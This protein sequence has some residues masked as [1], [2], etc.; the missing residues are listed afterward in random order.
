[1]Q[2]YADNRKNLKAFYASL[3]ETQIKFL[4]FSA[5]DMSQPYIKYIFR[6][7][8]LNKEYAYIRQGNTDNY[9][10]VYKTSSLRYIVTAP[11]TLSYKATP[12]AIQKIDKH[13]DV[14]HGEHI[15]FGIV[16]DSNADSTVIISHRTKYDLI[17][18]NFSFKRDTD[19]TCNFYLPAKNDAFYST[20]LNAT[21]YAKDTPNNAYVPVVKRGKTITMGQMFTGTSD[22]DIIHRLSRALLEPPKTG[23]M[24]PEYTRINGVKHKITKGPRGGKYIVVKGKKHYLQKG[25]SIAYKN[26]TFLSDTFVEFI[27]TYIL[28]PLKNIH[29][30]DLVS[31]QL[32]FDEENELDADSNSTITFQYDFL[33]RPSSLFYVETPML[34]AACYAFTSVSEGVL[35]QNLDPYEVEQFEEFQKIMTPNLAQVQ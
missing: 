5:T 24:R 9:Y 29:Q 32:F 30:D 31:V 26:V 12:V 23:G 17:S 14:Y 35:L 6:K 33:T 27:R 18:P 19:K 2:N 20:L 1:M 3:P 25:G 21:C 10:Y 15:T 34:L 28:V 4:Y 8:K 13:G 11:R 7:F 16:Y 22:L